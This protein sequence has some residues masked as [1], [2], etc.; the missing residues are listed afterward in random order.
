MN[1]TKD[2]LKQA[3]GYKYDRTAMVWMPENAPGT[4]GSTPRPQ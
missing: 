2:A 3:P 1:T 4:V